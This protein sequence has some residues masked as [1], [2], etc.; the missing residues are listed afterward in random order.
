MASAVD[1]EYAIFRQ[2]QEEIQKLRES[3][4]ILIHQRTE[5]EMVKQELDLLDGSAN[6]FKQVGPVLMRNDLDDAKQTVEKRLEFITGELKKNEE[7]LSSIEKKSSESAEKVQ[8]MQGAMQA[9]AAEMAKQ[10]A[11]EHGA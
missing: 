1:A 5:N 9:A 3:A 11:R 4:K 7:K 10:V 2:Y 6:V 8:K